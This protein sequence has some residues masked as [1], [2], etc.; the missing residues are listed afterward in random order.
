MFYVVYLILHCHSL[1]G[2]VVAKMSEFLCVLYKINYRGIIYYVILDMEAP[3]ADEGLSVS[4]VECDGGWRIGF[5]DGVIVRLRASFRTSAVIFTELHLQRGYTSGYT[6]SV[7]RGV[8]DCGDLAETLPYLEAA[9]QSP[10]IVTKDPL[11][12][13]L[14]QALDFVRGK[15]STIV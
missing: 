2:K 7:T 9:I 1:V 15:I 10:K 8:V 5:S 14:N 11:V 4:Y 6:V 13:T 3:M 12:Q